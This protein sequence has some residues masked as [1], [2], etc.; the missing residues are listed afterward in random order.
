M[1]D[2]VACRTPAEG[3]D[4]VTNIPRWK[5]EA[6]RGAILEAVD[7][8]GPRGLPFAKLPNAVKDR[9]RDETLERL[10]SVGWHVTTVK[11]EM[12]VA[13]EIRRRRGI[14]PQQIVAARALAAE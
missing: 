4:G 7:E 13:G 8:A 12:E 1:N 14:V 9:L 2:K 3:R 5:Y 11:L 10:G 6:V